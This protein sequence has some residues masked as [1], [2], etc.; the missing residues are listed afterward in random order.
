[1]SVILS[2]ENRMR[3]F[4]DEVENING[5]INAIL[6]LASLYTLCYKLNK[7]SSNLSKL[8]NSAHKM[9]ETGDNCMKFYDM[10]ENNIKSNLA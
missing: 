5:N 1:M 10:H 8:A 9:Y 2:V 3:E 7:S 6:K 4:S